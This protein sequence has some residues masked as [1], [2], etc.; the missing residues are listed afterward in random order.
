MN[1][2]NPQLCFPQPPLQLL[3]I[4]QHFARMEIIRMLRI[5]YVIAGSIQTDVCNN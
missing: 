1:S 4:H 3:L 5:G 2:L